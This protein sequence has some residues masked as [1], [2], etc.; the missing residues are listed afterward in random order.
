MVRALELARLDS[1]RAYINALAR[2]LPSSTRLESK[3]AQLNS[4][5]RPPARRAR[6]S[7]LSQN[8]GIFLQINGDFWTEKWGFSEKCF[9]VTLEIIP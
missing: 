7:Y 3:E 8:K 4:N 9:L 1:N 2:V 5:S 6:S